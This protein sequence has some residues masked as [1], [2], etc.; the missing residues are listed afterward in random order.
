VTTRF[1]CPL[2]CGWHYDRPP[3]D[4]SKPMPF[5]EHP[6]PEGV[7][8]TIW[9]FAAGRLL[10]D[11]AAIRI[12][13]ESHELIEWVKALTTVRNERDRLAIELAAA[14]AGFAPGPDQLTVTYTRALPGITD[15]TYE[16]QPGDGN[17]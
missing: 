11:E 3:L 13:A 15:H 9:G 7:D 12:H 2:D 4:P 6:A 17:H 1:L 5:A 14:R 10:A 16:G 8:P